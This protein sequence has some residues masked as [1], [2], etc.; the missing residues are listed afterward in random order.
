MSTSNRWRDTGP[1][2]PTVT[3]PVRGSKSVQ[4]KRP[5]AGYKRFQ[6]FTNTWNGTH[7]Q[8]EDPQRRAGCVM[9]VVSPSVFSVHG[10]SQRSMYMETDYFFS[11]LT[12]PFV[13][14]WG[15]T[16]T[17]QD[18]RTYSSLGIRELGAIGGCKAQVENIDR[19]VA[20]CL[21]APQLML[22]RPISR[23]NA[24]TLRSQPSHFLNY[25]TLGHV[26]GSQSVSHTVRVLT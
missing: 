10:A 9:I 24:T 25:R 2:T 20:Q 7:T 19:F 13:D 17:S 15:L 8:H 3:V 5:F 18:Q 16:S 6:C 12:W 23:R 26:K 21:L 1:C 22:S 4:R 11:V 14:Q